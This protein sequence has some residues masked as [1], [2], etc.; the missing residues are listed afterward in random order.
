ML[1]EMVPDPTVPLLFRFSITQSETHVILTYHQRHAIWL[2]AT[3]LLNA[4]AILTG[5]CRH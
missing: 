4:F 2:L 5:N 3:F 1:T